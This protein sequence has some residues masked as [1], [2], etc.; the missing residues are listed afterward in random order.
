MIP[1]CVLLNGKTYLN[2]VK[3]LGSEFDKLSIWLNANKLSVN[4]KKSYYMVYHRAKIKLDKHAA[5]KVNG[6]S[7]QS[8]NSFKYLGVIID[9][10]LNWTQHKHVKNKVSM[11]GHWYYVQG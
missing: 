6:V 3:L 9:H 5:I 7:L 8:T 11:H 2:L 4:V 1:S 10:K